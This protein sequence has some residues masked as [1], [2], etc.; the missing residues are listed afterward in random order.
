MATRTT[1]LRNT[2]VAQKVAAQQGLIT[3]TYTDAAGV[4]TRRKGLKVTSVRKTR[5][6]PDALLVEAVDTVGNVRTFRT[7]R[8]LRAIA[9]K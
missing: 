4:K 3:F 8:M 5:Q 1:V 6:N 7:D 9:G 2:G